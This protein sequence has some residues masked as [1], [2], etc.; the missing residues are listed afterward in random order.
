[1]TD[2]K[3]IRTFLALEAPDGVRGEMARIQERLRRD[4]SGSIRWVE[5][6]GMHLTLKFFGDL[7][8]GDI[9]GIAAAIRQQT[10]GVAPIRLVV[11]GL[12]VFPD[13]RRPRVVWLGTT[14][15]TDRLT[16]LQQGLDRSFAEMGFPREDRPFRAHWT[17]GRI[18][19]PQGLTGLTEALHKGG[20]L[21]AGTFQADRLV[22]MQSDLT[23]RGAVYTELD[24]FG[25]SG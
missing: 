8:P 2:G 1:M 9:P 24:S 12:G 22:L 14:G 3:A 20:R 21:V 19:S 13:T 10:T 25:L 5:A 4:V 18:K 16:R 15:E 17:L 23:P 6:A 7:D 11:E